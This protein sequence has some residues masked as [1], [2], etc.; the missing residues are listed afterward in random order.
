[1]PCYYQIIAYRYLV[2]I[3]NEIWSLKLQNDT[4]P[5]TQTWTIAPVYLSHL[6]I[7]RHLFQNQGPPPSAQIDFDI[8]FEK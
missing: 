7:L 1:M 4:S 6:L 2:H 5:Q 8:F 3:E